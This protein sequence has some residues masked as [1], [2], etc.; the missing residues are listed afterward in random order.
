MRDCLAQGEH[1]R[2]RERIS[3]LK[4]LVSTYAG[5]MLL[6]IGAAQTQPVI[7]H[8]GGTEGAGFDQALQQLRDPSS[9]L[10]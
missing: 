5:Q 2:V 7:C 10:E 8:F 6:H 9:L 3:Y 1:D 4:Q